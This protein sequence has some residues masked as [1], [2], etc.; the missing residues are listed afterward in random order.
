MQLILLATMAAKTAAHVVIHLNELK[1]A[2]GK[3]KY[4]KKDGQYLNMEK[5]VFPKK[6]AT[7]I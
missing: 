7:K 3:T 1:F 2:I 6:M 5:V 4:K